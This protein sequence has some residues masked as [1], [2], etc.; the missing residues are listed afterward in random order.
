[1]LP[2]ERRVFPLAEV[3]SESVKAHHSVSWW[4]VVVIGS[5]IGIVLHLK[6]V[7][8]LFVNITNSASPPNLECSPTNYS[9]ESWVAQTMTTRRPKQQ[10]TKRWD[11]KLPKQGCN[12]IMNTRQGDDEAPS[13]SQV[14]PSM[15]QT[16]T[17]HPVTAPT[18]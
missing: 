6:Y 10:K 18:W 7:R 11:Q 12:K 9:A 4:Y 1:M 3:Q 13:Q 17:S 15:L 5:S 2:C 16:P 8:Q 14:H